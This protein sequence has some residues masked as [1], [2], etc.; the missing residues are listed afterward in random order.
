MLDDCG[1]VA[2]SVDGAFLRPWRK[3]EAD[4]VEALRE[5]VT[6]DD[7]PTVIRYSKEK[8]P[9]EVPA[10]RRDRTVDILH[11]DRDAG[12]ALVVWGEFAG[13]ALEVA[14]RLSQQGIGVTVIDPLWT[15]QSDDVLVEHCSRHQLVVTLEDGGVRGGLGSRLSEQLRSRGVDVP[16]REFGLP[17][18]FIPHASRSEVLDDLGLTAPA[19]ARRA[20]EAYTALTADDSRGERW[21]STR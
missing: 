8:V 10:V 2:T 14:D 7:A 4:L 20:V 15:P 19:I 18:Q 6:V 11:A 5:A 12:V 13:L 1:S 9:D 17:Q 3:D 16:V 21:V